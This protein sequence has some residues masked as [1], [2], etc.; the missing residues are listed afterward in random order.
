MSIPAV[1]ALEDRVEELGKVSTCRLGCCEGQLTLI[2]A[3]DNH[4]IKTTAWLI[5]L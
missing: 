2:L 1:D 5:R 3:V 4:K